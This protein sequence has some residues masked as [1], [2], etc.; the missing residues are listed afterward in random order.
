M[1]VLADLPRVAYLQSGNIQITDPEIIQLFYDNLKG[2]PRDYFIN[3]DKSFD[4][5]FNWCYFGRF[6]IN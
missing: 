3:S 2:K 4:L 1:K 6:F 5:Y